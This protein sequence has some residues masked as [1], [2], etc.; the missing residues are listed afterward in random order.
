[1]NPFD[2]NEQDAREAQE[3]EWLADADAIREYEEWLDELAQD[4]GNYPDD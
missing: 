2:E 4:G 1:M 3:A